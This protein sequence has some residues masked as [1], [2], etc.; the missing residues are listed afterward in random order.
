MRSF[1]QRKKVGLFLG[2]ASFVFATTGVNA[3]DCTPKHQFKTVEQGFLTI[4]AP[5]FPPFSTPVSDSDITGVDGEIVKAIAAGECLKIKVAPVEYATAIPYVVSGRADIAIGNYYRTEERAKV[6]GIS[7]PL[8]LDE[9]GIYSKDG[10]SKI[11]DLVDRNVGTVQGYLWVNDLKA[12]LGSK[13]RLYNNYVALY[14]DLDTGRIDVGI[15]GVAV[16]TAAQKDG[17]LQG[18]QIKVAEKD[19]RVKSSVEA[20]QSGLMLSKENTELMT[21]VNAGLAGIRSSGKL[22][23]IL[24]QF[25]LSESAA[26]VGEARMVK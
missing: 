6:V 9:M 25:G 18:I 23:E 17:A 5:T 22:V 26:D 19:D 20:A 15:D 10:V 13:L 8:Y 11:A 24:K 1:S 21:A 3:Q 12:V 16:G 7:D 14:Q 2:L 4:A